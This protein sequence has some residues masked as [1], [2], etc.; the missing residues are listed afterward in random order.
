MPSFTYHRSEFS[1]WMN[2][3]TSEGKEKRVRNPEAE[4]VVSLL[5][6]NLYMYAGP[7]LEGNGSCIYCAEKELFII[8][9]CVLPI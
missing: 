3:K 8:V 6:P 1:L 9:N 7:F 5:G 2:S 4:T